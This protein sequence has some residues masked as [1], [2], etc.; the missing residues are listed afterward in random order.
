MNNNIL[1]KIRHSEDYTTVRTYDRKH[2]RSHY[3]YLSN[4]GFLEW[5]ENS[6]G[7]YCDRDGVDYMSVHFE[8]TGSY[9]VTLTFL[10]ECSDGSVTGYVQRFSIPNDLM[11]SV[12][13]GDVEEISYLANKQPRNV[14]RF[15]VSPGAHN[16]IANMPE[17][18]RRA[19]SKFMRDHFHY[20]APSTICIYSDG[21]ADFYFRDYCPS[22]L[23][24]SG[25]IIL[26]TVDRRHHSGTAFAHRY[27]MHT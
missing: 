26:S 18:I 12:A 16:N 19:F 11:I 25:G 7:T 20:N 9:Y 17:H 1:V 27:S 24:I 14:I 5:A 21:K 4:E 23:S 13:R 10:S 8:S 3:F 6:A 2:G 15:E 22:G